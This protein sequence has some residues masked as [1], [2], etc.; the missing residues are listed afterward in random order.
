MKR[1]APT[2]IAVV[3]FLAASARAQPL[4]LVAWAPGYPGTMEQAQPAMDEFARGL[5]AAAGWDSAEIGAVYSQDVAGGRI[6]IAAA[7]AGV[8]IVSLPAYLEYG[9]SLGLKPLLRVIQDGGEEETWSLV[10]RKGAIRGPADLSGWALQGLPGFSPRFVR[11]ALSTWGELP[12]DT[13]IEFNGRVLSVLRKAA[14]GEPV[15]TLLDRAQAAALARL[16]F[17]ADLEIVAVSAPMISSLFCEIGDRLP[18]AREKPLVQALLGLDGSASGTSVLD[19]IR[20]V[21]FET[22]DGAA[23]APY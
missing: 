16:P 12:A 13:E 21:R 10:A 18:D 1:I 23:I 22:L 20:V 8:A 7:D 5:A 11:D 17:A 19:T 2:V 9:K 6:R 4:T 15:A 14:A 3:F